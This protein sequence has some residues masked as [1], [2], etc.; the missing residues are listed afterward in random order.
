MAAASIGATPMPIDTHDT[1]HR[2]PLLEKNEQTVVTSVEHPILTPPYTTSPSD[3]SRENQ[4]QPSEAPSSSALST[5]RSSTIEVNLKRLSQTPTRGEPPK[6]RVKLTFAE[7]EEQ[8]L[9]KEAKVEQK[10]RERVE[11]EEKQRLKAEE[12]RAKNE[13]KEVKK[14]DIELAKQQKLEA[15]EKKARSQLRLTSLFVKPSLPA[16]LPSQLSGDAERHIA[17]QLESYDAIRLRRD[18]EQVPDLSASTGDKAISDYRK[19]FLPFCPPSHSIVAKVLPHTSAD[20]AKSSARGDALFQTSGPHDAS[21]PISRTFYPCQQR[22][23]QPPGVGEIIKA[24]QGGLATMPVGSSTARPHEMLEQV[25]LRHLHF[26]EDVR[27]PYFGSYTKI[28]NRQEMTKLSRRPFVKLRPDTNYDYDSEAEWEEPEEGED[29]LSEGEEDAESVDDGDE[30]SGFLDDEDDKDKIKARLPT[31][32][33]A[34]VCTPIAW[35]GDVDTFKHADDAVDLA[36]MRSEWLMN[37]PR[38]SINPLSDEYWTVKV[39]KQSVPDKADVKHLTFDRTGQ[40]T[41]Q[42]ALSKPVVGAAVNSKGPIMAAKT[43]RA[44]KAPVAKLVGE[45]LELF[46]EAVEGS[47]LSKLELLK[48]LKER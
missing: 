18:I 11:R 21:A 19:T 10:E 47:D 44:P 29:I 40:H 38:G 7:K 3:Q 9:L 24:I 36:T 39:P 12:R 34:P 15:S 41:P 45:R 43:T 2:A 6:K 30:M 5:V 1:A 33:F 16:S 4:R 27:P 14:R 46:R 28:N 42:G 8:R 48:A 35:E 17:T 22:G 26:A 37:V 25:T 32:D 20:D 23:F 13:E 31:S